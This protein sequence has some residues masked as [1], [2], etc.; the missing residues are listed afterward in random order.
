MKTVSFTQMKFGTKEDYEFLAEMEKPFFA[1]TADRVICELERHGK[2]TLSGYKITRLEPGCRRRLERV[3]TVPTW[4]GSSA[5]FS[6]IS[7]TVSRR[8]T[9]IGFPP[10]L[11]VRS[12]EKK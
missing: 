1:M 3:E 2:D 10:K 6:T 9:T 7:A 12:F 8:R 4:I 5:R 11:F